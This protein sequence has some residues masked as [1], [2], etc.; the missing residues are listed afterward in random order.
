MIQTHSQHCCHHLSCNCCRGGSGHS[1]TRQTKHTKNEDR[2][3]NNI[4]K[5]SYSL[6][7]HGINRLSCCLKQTFKHNLDKDTKRQTTA[8]GNILSAVL[9]DFFDICLASVKR[10]CQEQ[11]YQ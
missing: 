1:H 7:T 3:Q 4:G 9:H 5:R 6:R 11:S 8:D 2:V 10:L